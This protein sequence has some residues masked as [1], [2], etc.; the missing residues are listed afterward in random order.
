M[1]AEA[2]DHVLDSWAQIAAGPAGFGVIDDARYLTNYVGKFGE[3]REVNTPLR[4]VSAGDWRVTAVIKHELH[5]RARGRQFACDRQLL[6][7]Y[8]KIETQLLFGE[9]ADIG[10]EPLIARQIVWIILQHSANA[11]DAC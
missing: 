9:S 4:N 6:S 11:A 7:L 8:A 3:R 10:P 5:V 2:P 1:P